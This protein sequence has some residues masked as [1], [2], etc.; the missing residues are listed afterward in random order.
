MSPS[1]AK[2]RFIYCL[3]QQRCHL[4]LGLTLDRLLPIVKV[5][6]PWPGG[7][8]PIKQTRLQYRQGR[9]T[10]IT[11]PFSHFSMELG[12]GKLAQ[13]PT[14]APAI[15]M[16]KKSYVSNPDVLYLLPASMKLW[17]SN[18]LACIDGKNSDPSQFLK[19]SK[20]VFIGKQFTTQASSVPF[21]SAIL[22]IIWYS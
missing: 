4:P 2:G 12:L 21:P 13:M 7:S 17:Q 22:E 5:W 6:V 1:G 19:Q 20:Q 11:Q 14:L 18:L 15:V 9:T 16:K 3:K 8:S 10:G